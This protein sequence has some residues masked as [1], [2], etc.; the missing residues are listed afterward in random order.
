MAVSIVN[1]TA[2]ERVLDCASGTG[3]FLAM[4]AVHLVNRVLAERYGTTPEEA[5]PEVLLAAQQEVRGVVSDHFFGREMDPDLAVPS[6]LNVLFT[7]GHPVRVFRLD[8]LSFPNGTLDGLNA[9]R[10]SIPDE[11][12]DVVLTKLHITM[13][14]LRSALAYTLTSGRD[15]DE[16]HSLYVNSGDGARSDVVSSYYFNS[17]RGGEGSPDRLLTLLRE[18]DVG[19]ASNPD[20]DRGL[21][22]LPPDANE[23]TYILASHVP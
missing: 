5:A 4:A 10:V 8:S 9:A 18:I 17:W 7:V 15:C 6:R 21:D 11:S 2:G 1:P 22:Y 13:R 19:E 12:M 14:D 20:L 3:T 16:I 23:G